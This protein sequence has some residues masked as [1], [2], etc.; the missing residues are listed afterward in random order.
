MK[1]Q[2]K[3]KYLSLQLFNF[4]GLSSKLRAFTEMGRR[5]LSSR[6]HAPVFMR[7][8]G[9]GADLGFSLVPDFSTYC[10]IAVWGDIEHARLHLEDQNFAPNWKEYSKE[11]MQFLLKCTKVHGQWDGQNMLQETD[12]VSEGEPV[13][14][15]TRARLKFNKL[16]RFWNHVPMSSRAIANADACLFSKGIGEW[17]L[18]SLATISVWEDP[19]KMRSFAYGNTAHAEIVKKVRE[20]GWFSEELFARFSIMEVNGSYNE[21][22]LKDALHAKTES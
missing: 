1:R 15:L 21:L 20:E 10:L 9:S 7:H 14:V 17:P 8:M 13:L 4:E 5:P 3:G 6:L 16:G 2:K 18:I 22:K 12:P 11:R 19:E